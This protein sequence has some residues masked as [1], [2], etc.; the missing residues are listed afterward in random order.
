MYDHATRTLV[1]KS[2]E[3]FTVKDVVT[4]VSKRNYTNTNDYIRL[5][6]NGDNITESKGTFDFFYRLT[7]MKSE[8][9]G[10]WN[11]IKRSDF[12]AQRYRL[13]DSEFS[14]QNRIAK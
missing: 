13:S 1:F 5:R 3:I 2:D 7:I 12:V 11:D 6:F 9:G 8:I 4:H 10:I 14:T